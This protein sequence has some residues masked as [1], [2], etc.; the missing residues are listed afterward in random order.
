M[1]YIDAK[2]LDRAVRQ[3]HGSAHHLL[4]IWLTLKQMGMIPGTPV[5]IT[6]SSP[7]PALTRLFSYGDPDGK[8]FIPFAH[9]ERFK[10]MKGDAARSIIQTTIQRWHASGSVVE[11]DPTSFL[12]ISETKSGSLLAEPGRHYPEGLGWGPNGFALEENM[13]VALPDMAFCVW[14][15][16]KI[17]LSAAEIK[18]EKLLAK[19]SSDLNLS[20]AEMKLIFVPKDLEISTQNKALTDS[21]IYTIVEGTKAAWDGPTQVLDQT[22]PEHL[23]KIRSMVTIKPGPNWLN[24]DGYTRFEQALKDGAKAIL[25]YGPPRTGKTHAIDT[26]VLRN[27]KD[28][29]TIQIHDGWGYEDLMLGLRPKKDGWVYEVGPLLEAIRDGK[30]FIV[31]EE[32]N[33]TDFSQAIGDTFSLIEEDYRGKEHSIQLKNGESFFIPKEVTIIC[34]MNTLDRSTEEIDDALFGRMLAIEFQPRVE[35]L[36]KMLSDKGID[37]G[38]SEKLRELFATILRYYPLG[39]AY[40]ADFTPKTNPIDYYLSRVRPVLQKH[41]QNYRDDDIQAI[42]EKVDSLFTK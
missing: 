32:I 27:S 5:E 19:L 10:T 30:K 39:H 13:R 11:V 4:K 6:T 37:E 2:T 12:S 3:L 17:N 15:Y 28:R 34:T 18:R 23:A 14:Y 24:R 7:T 31:L 22:L 38:I 33:R 35:D 42:D 41:L 20:D 29:V 40:F 8:F 36:H 1:A 26:A 9:T 25:L 21:Q 16:R